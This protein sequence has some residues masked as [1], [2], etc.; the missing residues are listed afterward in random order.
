MQKLRAPL[1]VTLFVSVLSFGF[2]FSEDGDSKKIKWRSFAEAIEKGKAENKMIVVDFYTDWCS[3]CKLMDKNTYGNSDVISYAGKNLI[4][5]KVDAES[6][7]KTKFR[8]KEYSYRQLA[9]GFG[10]RAYPTTVFITPKGEFLTD[11]KGYIPADKFIPIL[12]FLDGK[13]YENMEFEEY[14]AKREAR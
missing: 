9:M 7:D 5:T 12:E 13:H 10:V 1:F 4:M 14:L 3:A 8:G 2:A 11:I 6:N